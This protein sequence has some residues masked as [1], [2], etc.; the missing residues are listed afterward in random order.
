MGSHARR[1]PVRAHTTEACQDLDISTGDRETH[2]VGSGGQD[3]LGAD[4]EL[5]DA[6]RVCVCVCAHTT[7]GHRSACGAARRESVQSAGRTLVPALDDLAD[8]NLGL[9]WLAPE[10]RVRGGRVSRS[11]AG[12][13]E[14]AR[15]RTD[16]GWSRTWCRREACRRSELRRG[17]GGW[18]MRRPMN[19]EGLV[20]AGGRSHIPP[21]WGKFLPSPGERTSTVTP[22]RR[23]GA[24]D[25]AHRAQGVTQ[26]TDH[27]C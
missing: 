5:W 6:W 21:L 18:G 12:R 22:W 1:T 14:R 11:G 17:L 10:G 25:A 13:S 9:E 20:A 8:A 23:T 16:P 26:E 15:R 19:T 24:S 3:G 27:G 7:H 4:R 2:V